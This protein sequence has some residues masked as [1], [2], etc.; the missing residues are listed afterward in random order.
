MSTKVP[1][2]DEARVVVEL[3]AISREPRGIFGLENSTLCT[4]LS[5][6]DT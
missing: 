6:I 3:F 2:C 4:T 1:N 5:G